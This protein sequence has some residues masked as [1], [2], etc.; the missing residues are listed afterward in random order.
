MA[1]KYLPGIAICRPKPGRSQLRIAAGVEQRRNQ[2]N[3]QL[4]CYNAD[5][6]VYQEGIRATQSREKTAADGVDT[7]NFGQLMF[8]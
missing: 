2:A 1:L 4:N 7:K 8:R 5:V 6:I 3:I